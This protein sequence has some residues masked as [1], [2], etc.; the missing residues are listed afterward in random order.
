MQMRKMQKEHKINDTKLTKKRK[1]LKSRPVF[2]L[3]NVGNP[4]IR[5]HIQLLHVFHNE[6]I[7]NAE[8]RRQ[9]QTCNDSA[10]GGIRYF[11]APGNTAH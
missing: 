5:D 9:R 8:V 11:L 1:N 4:L 7:I 10:N 6:V 3:L 2:G